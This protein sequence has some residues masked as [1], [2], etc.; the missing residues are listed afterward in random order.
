MT[1]AAQ[2]PTMQSIPCSENNSVLESDLELAARFKLVAVLTIHETDQGYYLTAQFSAR[3]GRIRKERVGKAAYPYL[4][5]LV[6]DPAKIWYLTSR[7]HRTAPRLH[8][9]L[10]RL[11]ELMRDKYPT[12]RVVL[13]RNQYLPGEPRVRGRPKAEQAAE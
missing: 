7:R 11:N 10:G 8:R 1:K 6:S 13:L 9:S 3:N 2:Q 12:D 5:E 4:S